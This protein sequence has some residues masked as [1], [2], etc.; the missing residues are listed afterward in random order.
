MDAYFLDWLALF[1]RWFHIIAGIAWI[2]ASF[3]FIWLDNHLE[4]PPDWKEERGIKGEL[5]AIHGGGIYEVSK[6]KLAPGSMPEVLHWFKWEAYTTWLTGM[7]L[8][9][10][11]YYLGAEA[12]L[13]D[14]TIAELSQGQAIGLGLSTIFLSYISYEL[15]CRSPL[16]DNSLTIAIILVV[17]GTVL[18]Y[19]LTHLFSGRGAFMHF[20]AVIGTIMVGNVFRVI[21][22]SQKALVTAVEQG[23]PLDPAWGQRAKLHST[24]NTYL[25]LPIIF[26]MISGHYSMTYSHSYNWLILIAICGITALVR[27]YF[28]LR[29]KKINRPIILAGSSMAVILLA[30]LIAPAP[31][32]EQPTEASARVNRDQVVKIINDRCVQCHSSA[33]SDE[34][35]KV[36][37][38]GVF[39]DDWS[40]IE[41]WAPRIKA[42]AVD[43]REMPFMNKTEM[44]DEERELLGLWIAGGLAD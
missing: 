17:F 10:L 8:M 1:F 31:I 4:I 40:Q 15:L 25:T 35:F 27:H 14:P 6:Y 23:T 22:P 18:A 5:W 36:A 13:I 26:I 34:I 37:P 44:L 43:T 28:V 20:G 29:H 42:R 9:T 30:F 16:K 7:V 32:F 3:Y 41:N 12:Y 24:H 21:I 33:P 11:I 19:G 2:G 38:S 39:L